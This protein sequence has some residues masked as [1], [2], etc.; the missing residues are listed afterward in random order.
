MWKTAIAFIMDIFKNL[1]STYHYWGPA[2]L[3]LQL[4]LLVS[5]TVLYLQSTYYVT[6]KIFNQHIQKLQQLEPEL[7]NFK[8]P[9]G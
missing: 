5:Y 4:T 8:N 6:T 3:N 2:Y 1:Q 7:K 9:Y